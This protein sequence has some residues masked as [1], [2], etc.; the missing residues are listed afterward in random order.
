MTAYNWASN[1][2]GAW[3]TG[4]L[5]ALASVP[6]NAAADVTI[7]APTVFVPY[8]ITIASGQTE[9]IHSLSINTINNH[10]GAGIPGDY[11]A[12]ELELDG[13]LVFAAGSP[14]TL[15]GPLQT[16]V[17]VSS[18]NNAKVVNGGTLSA[19]IQ[20]EGNLLLTGTNGIYISN[21]L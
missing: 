7:D 6:N 4:T 12:A 2:S 21:E 3:N 11:R 19:F 16:L 14:G 18:G 20:V 10:D 8:T 9:T 5:W 15:S 17:H 1:V 13:T